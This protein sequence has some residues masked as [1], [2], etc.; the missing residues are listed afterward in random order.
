[1]L[2]L[3]RSGGCHTQVRLWFTTQICLLRGGNGERTHT[4]SRSGNKTLPQAA[5]HRCCEVV[6]SCGRQISRGSKSID[7]THPHRNPA[8][9]AFGARRRS[10]H[11]DQ[12]AQ[13]A[14]RTRR[15]APRPQR[16]AGLLGQEAA[17]ATTSPLRQRMIEDMTIR[18][19]SQATQQSYINAVINRRTGSASGTCARLLHLIAQKRSWLP[20]VLSPEEIARFL[21]A[22]AGL[23]KRV[24][25]TTPTRRGSAS[26]RFA[27]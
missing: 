6:D 10:V 1:M 11:S 9:P 16:L 23:R 4:R 21:E 25:L 3:H 5:H 7:R 2:A 18:N 13:V 22:V 20:P 26:E 8:S 17:T 24:A 15:F 19:L 12:S 14:R 27:V